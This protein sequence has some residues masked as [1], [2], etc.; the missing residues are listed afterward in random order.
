[1]EGR[2][3]RSDAKMAPASLRNLARS[4][5]RYAEIREPPTLETGLAWRRD[6]ETPTLKGLLRLLG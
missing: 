4:G 1:M 3:A 5:V 6:D 2:R